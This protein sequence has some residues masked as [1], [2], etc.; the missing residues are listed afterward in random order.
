MKPFII[1]FFLLPFLSN[2]QDESS[3]DTL[4]IN[5]DSIYAK[6]G[7]SILHI[8]YDKEVQDGYLDEKNSVFIFRKTENGI[9]KEIYRD[10]IFS[11]V[12]EINFEDFNN[13][14]VKDILVQNISDVRSNYTY[15]LYLVNPKNYTLTKIKGF[16]EIKNPFYNSEYN[17]V[18]SR[19]S[20]GTDYTA[21][22]KIIKTHVYDYKIYV[23]DNHEENN[24]YDEEYDKAL[25]KI[26]Q[27]N[28]TLFKK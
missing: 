19:V 17:I 26:L 25:K 6:K 15:I 11:R 1:I 27:K 24:N 13:D 16:E 7:F 5:C 22:Y 21:F 14:K 2:A 12:Q 28:K 18:E 8:T 3:I 20:S 10:T 9:I 23:D 4:K